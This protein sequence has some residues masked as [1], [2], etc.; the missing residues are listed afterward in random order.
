MGYYIDPN[1][2]NLN[3]YLE[4][5]QNE[6]I[7]RAQNYI[8]EINEHFNETILTEKEVINEGCRSVL[9][10]HIILPLLKKGKFSEYGEAKRFIKFLPD[11]GLSKATAHEAI[12]LI[13]GSGG[14]SVLAHPGVYTPSW[15]EIYVMICKLKDEGID[16]VELQ[17]PYCYH[18]Q[19]W[20]KN[21][22]AEDDFVREV[23]KLGKE[24]GLIFTRGSDSHSLEDLV[25]LTAT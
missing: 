8:Q 14:I 3:E 15:E 13:K 20:Y 12:E 6:R 24:L 25:L 18:M 19:H 5:I 23:E 11:T 1:N 22:E 17:Y 16:G 7:I 4:K 10:P 21:K 2:K 9:Q